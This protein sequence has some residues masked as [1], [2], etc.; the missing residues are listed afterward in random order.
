MSK[1]AIMLG[2]ACIAGGTALVAGTLTLIHKLTH[3]SCLK[4]ND[5]DE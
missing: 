2:I 4:T 3:P 1:V 5:H